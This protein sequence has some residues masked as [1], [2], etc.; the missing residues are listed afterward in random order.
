VLAIAATYAGARYLSPQKQ[1]EWAWMPGR[2]DL[3]CPASAAAPAPLIAGRAVL[4]GA[5]EGGISA[6]RAEP[7]STIW[8][9]PLYPLAVRAF[10]RILGNSYWAAFAVSNLSRLLAPCSC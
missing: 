1:A 6:P 3:Q 2:S 8:G 5:G 7:P 10:E 9:L 4:S